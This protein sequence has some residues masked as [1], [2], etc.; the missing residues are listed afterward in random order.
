MAEIYRTGVTDSSS[1]CYHKAMPKVLILQNIEREGPGLFETTLLSAN[2]PYDVIN[3]DSD[4]Q[5]PPIDSYSA[6]VVLGGPDSA[7]DTTDKITKELAYIS[8]ALKTGKPYLGI[9]LG[10][11]LLVKASGGKVVPASIK[12]VGFIGPDSKQHAVTITQEG[13]SD[14]LLTG[15]SEDVDVFQLHGETVELTPTMTVLATG[16]F[17]KNQIVRVSEKAYGIQSHFELTSEMLG[18]WAKQ[19]SDL[20]PIGN[21]Q[22]QQDFAAIQTSYTQTGIKLFTNFLALAGLTK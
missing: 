1:I 18:I 14:P 10:L 15:M 9:C 22:L 21:D 13:K 5:L 17:C 4:Q 19:D 7:N 3:L 11:Q 12:E 16:K 2:I 20:I 6:L 8:S